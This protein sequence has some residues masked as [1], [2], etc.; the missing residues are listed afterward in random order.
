MYQ[1]TRKDKW[2]LYTALNPLEPLK[3]LFLSD[4][5]LDY[6]KRKYSPSN[7]KG[8]EARFMEE[9]RRKCTGN[10][11]LII[12]GDIFNDYR[13]TVAFANR[14]E[15]EQIRG[16]FVMGNHDYWSGLREPLLGYRDIIKYVDEHTEGNNHFRFLCTGKSYDIQGVTFIG[17]TGWTSYRSKKY[18][19]VPDLDTLPSIEGDQVAWFSHRDV[20]Y[21]HDQWIDFA[22]TVYERCRD[23]ITVTHFPMVEQKGK[24]ANDFWWSSVTKLKNKNN[25]CISGH[26]HMSKWEKN[27]HI[28]HQR[29]YENKDFVLGELEQLLPN[30][31]SENYPDLVQAHLTDWY[32]FNTTISAAEASSRGFKRVSANR[33][34]MA[35]IIKDKEAYIRRIERGIE[36]YS[37]STYGGFT[38]GTPVEAKTFALLRLC[39]EV[40]R[41]DHMPDVRT[42]MIAVVLTGYVYNHAMEDLPYARPLDNLDVVRMFLLFMTLSHFDIQ[43]DEVDG[44]SKATKQRDFI[45]FE[46]YTVWLPKVE[47]QGVKYVIPVDKVLE[48][49]KSM[50]FFSSPTTSSFLLN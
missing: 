5:H 28:A 25:W 36:G 37:V 19:G 31:T 34:N 27:N 16:F 6:T 3:L 15:A 22:N 12:A 20:L 46:G 9:V 45:T 1:I 49:T 8:N 18:K 24:G 4:L 38:Y 41:M 50:P 33:K 7:G 17:D 44:V 29:G 23:V 39:L 43:P 10:Y 32:E 47:S 13:E 42:Y 40:L 30:L 14:L 2:D 11:V 48:A 35:S 26:S 21:M